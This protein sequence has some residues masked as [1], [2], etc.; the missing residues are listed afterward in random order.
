MKLN[1]TLYLGVIAAL[2]VLAAVLWFGKPAPAPQPPTAAPIAKA[3]PPQTDEAPVAPPTPPTNTML[4]SRAAVSMPINPTQVGD[5]PAM[6]EP[7]A[8]YGKVDSVEQLQ[9]LLDEVVK[10]T[11]GEAPQKPLLAATWRLIVTTSARAFFVEMRTDA[12]GGLYARD[13]QV[14]TE[15]FFVHGTCRVRQERIVSE[16]R[17]EQNELVHG[18]YLGQLAAVPLRVKRTSLTMDAVI[19]TKDVVYLQLPALREDEPI[20][21]QISREDATIALAEWG[22]IAVVPERNRVEEDWGTPMAWSVDAAPWDKQK[23]PEKHTRD[24]K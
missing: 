4:P 13:E 8:F 6:R 17:I 18:L 16:C 9:K 21:L 23:G 7:R 11:G 1:Q 12:E 19:D 10:A 24:L 3:P 2:A 5:V 20:R 15:W 22:A 14:G